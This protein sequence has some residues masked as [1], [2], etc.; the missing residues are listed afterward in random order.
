MLSQLDISENNITTLKNGA[1]DGI[2]ELE[3][4]F[5][6]ENKLKNINP[7]AFGLH[8]KLLFM[9]FQDNELTDFPEDIINERRPLLRT[10][11]INGN[12]LAQEKIDRIIELLA[13][14]LKGT[15]QTIKGHHE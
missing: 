14:R 8:P 1:F 4:L 2:P 9:S 15:Q 13:P 10:I 12:K 7:K 5:V 3:Y 11:N 6:L